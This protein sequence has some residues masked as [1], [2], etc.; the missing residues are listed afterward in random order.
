MR[1]AKV[2]A[3]ILAVIFIFSCGK[4]EPEDVFIPSPLEVN[5]S[6]LCGN[7]RTSA[8]LTLAPAKSYP[9][10][11]TGDFITAST[12]ENG[13]HIFNL[14]PRKYALSFVFP[15]TRTVFTVVAEVES[16]NIV[17]AVETPQCTPENIS[18]PV[19]VSV[20]GTTNVSGQR[21]YLGALPGRE[22]TSLSSFSSGDVYYVSALSYPGSSGKIELIGVAR[23]GGGPGVTLFGR[24]S[25]TS[26]TSAIPLTLSDTFGGRAE[27]TFYS[28]AEEFE[29]PKIASYLSLNGK[30]NPVMTLEVYENLVAG[31][32]TTSEVKSAFTVRIGYPSPALFKPSDDAIF[33]A[34][35]EAQFASPAGL[36][37]K[38]IA[39][40]KTGLST[41]TPGS[42]TL[43]FEFYTPPSFL[44][45]NAE[46]YLISLTAPAEAETLIAHIYGEDIDW[47]IFKENP[48]NDR[49]VIP[50]AP[51]KLKKGSTYTVDLYY[52]STGIKD[53]LS[54]LPGD[55]TQVLELLL[56][57]TRTT[58]V[59]VLEGVQIT[60]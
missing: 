48:E 51:L 35:G 16:L 39:A 3:G 18:F 7:P 42:F 14:S 41:D 31:A 29:D 50:Y 9:E 19:R 36:T 5:I 32:G 60:P 38:S 24:T 20:S 57:L 30:V 15:S 4:Q 53:I 46:E 44:G 45:F 33:T 23:G 47:W 52:T 1:K 22:V 13:T 34:I 11:L 17:T 37:R 54:R 40:W 8:E 2:S 6:D 49:F 43:Q 21:L 26:L 58:Y 55:P 28:T 10:V 56:T 27:L 25:L 12:D 59:G